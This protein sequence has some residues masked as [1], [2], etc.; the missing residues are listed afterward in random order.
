MWAFLLWLLD[1]RVDMVSMNISTPPS[2]PFSS[3]HNIWLLNIEDPVLKGE[4]IL[5]MRDMPVF[6][7]PPEKLGW[8]TPGCPS[9]WDFWD[10]LLGN[11]GTSI[12]KI[13]SCNWQCMFSFAYTVGMFAAWNMS[14]SRYFRNTFVDV[15][16]TSFFFSRPPVAQG[17]WVCLFLLLL[18]WVSNGWVVTS[19]IIFLTYIKYRCYFMVKWFD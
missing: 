2:R 1:V 4:D 11:S 7:E 3:R 17:I 10:A 13:Q 9:P 14:S 5:S 6:E 12:C 15:L 19:R 16:I 8:K 18:W